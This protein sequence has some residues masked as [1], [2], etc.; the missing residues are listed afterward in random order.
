MDS[1]WITTDEVYSDLSEKRVIRL[2]RFVA[3]FLGVKLPPIEF[4][5]DLED[6]ISSCTYYEKE[7]DGVYRA[8]SIVVRKKL[9]K[10]S[11]ENERL[12]LLCS[13]AY[14]VRHVY[15]CHKLKGRISF[16]NK[17]GVYAPREIDAIGF[18]NLFCEYFLGA[19]E[20][21]DDELEKSLSQWERQ[22]LDWFQLRIIRKYKKEI[23]KSPFY[24][25]D[26]KIDMLR[27]DYQDEGIDYS[28]VFF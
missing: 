1:I 5:D 19:R 21:Y 12:L 26:I 2:A 4:V 13:I 14:E 10:Y 23:Q 20:Q 27:L 18:A 15:Q 22:F 11:T 28:S 17:E 24:H 8:Q 3:N 9:L 16:D 25:D 7:S 6:G